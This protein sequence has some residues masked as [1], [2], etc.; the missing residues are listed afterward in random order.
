MSDD[1]KSPVFPPALARR[2]VVL[3]AWW[4]LVTAFAPFALAPAA[5][6][7]T[8]QVEASQG[9]PGLNHST[10]SRFLAAHMADAGLADWRFE[11]TQGDSEAPDRVEWTFRLNPYAGGEVRNFAR[12]PASESGFAFRRPVTIEARFYLN[13]HY[14]TLVEKQ[15]AI[16]AGPDD[17]YLASAVTSVTEDLLGPSGA[18]QAITRNFQS[19]KYHRE[20]RL[21]QRRA[22]LAR[23]QGSSCLC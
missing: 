15:A 8:L 17:S 22:N 7:T 9:L 18:Y 16:R 23:R 4:V 10:L 19:P 20:V 3:L 13:G 12:S 1:R 14:H 6:Q 2:H 11:P 5:A 21:S